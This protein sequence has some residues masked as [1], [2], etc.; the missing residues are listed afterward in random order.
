M[1]NGLTI[2]S[3]LA[4]SPELWVG[5]L[6]EYDPQFTKQLKDMVEVRAFDPSTKAWWFP[7]S[8]LPFV[9]NLM[10]ELKCAPEKMVDEASHVIQAELSRR[11]FMKVNTDV[12]GNLNPK[13]V[14]AY[15]TLGLHPSASRAFVEWA[16]IFQRREAQ[17]LAIP[18]TQ[19]LKCEE[20]YRLICGGV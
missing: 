13:L 18:Q 9:K 15:A 5:A 11:T 20:A 6:P 4:L 14:E 10:R 19:L 12:D 3:V 16:I 2:R 7:I 1:K 17:T 8:Y